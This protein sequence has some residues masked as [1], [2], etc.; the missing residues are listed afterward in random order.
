M[1]GRKLQSFARYASYAMGIFIRTRCHSAKP[2]KSKKV[3]SQIE[4][5]KTFIDHMKVECRGGKGGDGMISFLSLFANQYAGPGGGD[6]GNGG[7]V[8]FKAS[9]N[10][11]SLWSV[12][13][14][15]K[16]ENG[17]DGKSKCCHGSSAKHTV[18]PVPIGTYFKDG[19]GNK[20][21]DLDQEDQ[22][23]VGARGGAGGHGNHY[24]LSNMNRHPRIA[25]I[26]A[27]G[28][29][30][31]Y[32]LELKT[33]A[34]AGLIGFPN[35]GKSTFLQAIS[36]AKPKVASYPFTTLNPHVGM[37]QYDDYE[38]V[39]VADLPGIVSGSHKDKGLGIDFLRH[40]ER[41]ICLLYV[42]DL[43]DNEPWT[44]FESLQN[45]LEMYSAGLSR[46]P[47][48]IIGNKIDMPNA[49]ENLQ[50]LQSRVNLP[51]Y[52]ISAKFGDNIP[53]ILIH[54]RELYDKYIINKA[55]DRKK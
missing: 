46:R 27:A 45:E 20:V 50:K 52:A 47:H 24:F 1:K 29:I 12:P 41:C 42:I 2:L 36:R 3:K 21:M 37:I 54:L 35:A 14:I 23:F 8:V 40:I 30:N 10:V 51:I 4:Y 28:E 18:I 48:A 16:G 49:N 55:N 11:Q 43:S 31:R 25:E 39:A 13:S 5:A 32:S 9:Y 17:I 33:L 53:S 15:I 38:Q 26:G 6:G 34:H 44:Q 7:H 22:I 19:E